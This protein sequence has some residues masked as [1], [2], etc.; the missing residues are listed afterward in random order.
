[1]QTCSIR[2]GM[3]HGSLS[4]KITV[5]DFREGVAAQPINRGNGPVSGAG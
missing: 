5:H 1:V 3:G 4:L 2:V